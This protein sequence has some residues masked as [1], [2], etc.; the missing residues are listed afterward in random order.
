MSSHIG[1]MIFIV[2]CAGGVQQGCTV[3][4]GGFAAN[5][6]EGSSESAFEG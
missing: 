1:N 2:N 5:N 6:K 4:V 3:I